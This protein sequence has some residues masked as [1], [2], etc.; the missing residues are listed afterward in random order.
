MKVVWSDIRE[1]QTGDC[2]TLWGKSAEFLKDG[3]ALPFNKVEGWEAAGF[4]EWKFVTVHQ[5]KQLRN[6][7][8]LKIVWWEIAGLHECDHITVEWFNEKLQDCKIRAPLQF[9]KAD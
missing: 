8:S 3:T 6:N 7:K 4:Q 9:I 1:L 2:I 5:N